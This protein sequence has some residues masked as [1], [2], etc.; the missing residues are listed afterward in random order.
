MRYF[1]AAAFLILAAGVGLADEKGV[2]VQ[3][4]ASVKATP[5]YAVLSLGVVSEAKSAKAALAKN[6]KDMSAVFDSLKT[7]GID[8]KDYSSRG[9]NLSSV[10]DYPEKG[11]AK[12]TGYRV[13]NGI[14]VRVKKLD[15]LGTII[16]TL[17]SEGANSVSGVEYCVS[18][19]DDKLD[20][21]RTAAVANAKKKA[22]LLLKGADDGSMLGRVRSITESTTSRYS[23]MSEG[24]V[25]RAAP[26]VPINPGER[27]YTIKVSVVFDIGEKKP[28]GLKPRQ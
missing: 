14:S 23:D 5:D 11:P 1:L 26:K 9:F 8:K 2:T 20:E 22:E 10:Y 25:F 18:D 28:T 7:L 12:L 27:E 4:S 21:A 6:N 19:L 13:S 17:V 15:D 16:D 24:G 3:G